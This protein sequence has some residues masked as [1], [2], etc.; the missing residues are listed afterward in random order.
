MLVFVQFNFLFSGLPLTGEIADHAY[1]SI[2]ETGFLGGQYRPVAEIEILNGGKRS[3][4][5]KSVVRSIKK[6]LKITLKL[7]SQN[8]KFPNHVEW[9]G[10]LP[11]QF[12]I[13]SATG[14]D[15]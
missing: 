12:P 2:I 7:P 9:G 13:I 11:P 10:Q 15:T 3:E 14:T 8:L 5:S 4:F 1:R 6:Y